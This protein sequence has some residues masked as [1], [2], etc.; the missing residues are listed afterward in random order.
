V[1]VQASPLRAGKRLGDSQRNLLNRAA[2]AGNRGRSPQRSQV[3]R[4]NRVRAVNRTSSASGGPVGNA[5][6]KATLQG[7]GN[8]EYLRLA[9]RL[10]GQRCESIEGGVIVRRG[11]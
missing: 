8:H 7:L 3:V 11:C 10:T 5:Y 2:R 6:G 9:G 4:P 1:L